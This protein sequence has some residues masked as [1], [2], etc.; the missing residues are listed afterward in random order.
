MGVADI[1]KFNVMSSRV[2]LARNVEGLPFP[3]SKATYNPNLLLDLVGGAYKASKNVFDSELLL[4]SRLS[5]E[6]KTTL[7]E[8]HIISLPLANNTATGAV[9]IEKGAENLS[10]MLNEEDHIREQCVMDGLDLKSAYQKIDRYDDS[11]IESLPIAFDEQFGFLTACP[12]NVGTGMR[13]STMLFLPSLKLSGEIE[14]VIL[15]FT[16]N[17]GLTIRGIYGEGSQALGD[18]YQLSNSKTLGFDESTLINLVE[19]ATMEM[20]ERELISCAKLF[21][22]KGNELLDKIYRSYGILKSAYSISSSE[23]MKLVSD[24]KLGIIL[25]VL[26]IK[27]TRPLDKLVLFSSASSMTIN[28]GNYDESQRDIIRA[29]IVRSVLAENC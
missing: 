1:S 22:L 25:N 4:M 16:K 18:M 7:V 10:I 15:K 2:R 20:C 26:P 28:I 23:L 17:Y 3:R 29:K 6:Q 24:V 27:D 8:R 12:T 13:A 14:N 21:K 9:I 5:K 11:L 19:Q